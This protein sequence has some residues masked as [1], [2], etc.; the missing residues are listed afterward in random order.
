MN[1]T[2]T[3]NEQSSD[4]QENLVQAGFLNRVIA[5]T[6]DFIIVVALLELIPRIGYF[7]G[8]AY[9]LA[10]DGLF[11]GRSVGK[12]LTGL[13][14]VLFSNEHDFGNCSYKGSIYRNFPF[15]AGYILCGIVG[16]IPLIGWIFSFAIA[17]VIVVFE[18]L[19]IIGSDMGMRLGDEIAKTQVVEDKQGVV[20]VQ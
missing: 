2:D 17:A 10:A 1:L 16:A 9:L 14:V 12:R 6:I 13:R 4:E 8:L 5:R 11:N 19:L 3:L 20:N 18:C 15:A 7:A